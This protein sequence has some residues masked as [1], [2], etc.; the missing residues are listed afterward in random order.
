M[1]TV[2]FLRRPGHDWPLIL[3]ANR[4]EMT[5]RPWRPPARHW[6]DRPNVV[7]GI[8]ELAGGTWLGMND[9]GVVAGILNRSGSLGPAPG[10]RSRGEIV[11]EALDHADAAEAA[12][13]L[14][15]LDTNAY[16]PFNLFVADNRDAFWLRNDGD[17]GPGHVEVFPLPDGI[18]VLTARDLNDSRSNRVNNYLPRF[19][20]A[21]A[22]DPM[23]C[24]WVGWADLLASRDRRP[25]Q[26]SADAMA[27]ETDFGFATVSSSLIAIPAA[28]KFDD[29]IDWRFA[30]GMPGEVPFEHVTG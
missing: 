11:L 12:E 23:N 19:R 29:R 5:D 1:C 27:I 2:I 24:S 3:G 26:E 8:D 30:A 14:G 4:D 9:E 6:A 7:A 15:A 25:G 21:P 16:R 17:A 22:P 18:S 13:A 20:A 10:K 28:G